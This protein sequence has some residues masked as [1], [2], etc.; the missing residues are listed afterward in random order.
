[1]SQMDATK[2]VDALRKAMKG[3]G[4]DEA[5]LIKI[6]CKADPLYV[7]S[8][9]H[10]FRQR[11]GR[12]LEKDVKSEVSGKLEKV[13]LACLRGPL[14]QDVYAVRTAVKGLGTNED[15]LNDVLCGRS[16][17]DLRVIKQIYRHEHNRSL[18]EDVADDLSGRTK[19]LFAMITAANRAEESA[20]IDPQAVDRDVHELYTSLLKPADADLL[21]VCRVF[22]S[23]SNAQLRAIEQAYTRRHDPPLAKKLSASTMGH[24]KDALLA[25]LGG[26]TDPVKRDAELLGRALG[27]VKVNDDLLIERVVRLHWNK[28]HMQ[29]VKVEFK[30]LMKKDLVQA[31]GEATS[32]DYKKAMLAVLEG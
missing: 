24:M 14:L 2:D 6:L 20:P 5:T 30:K 29:A 7:E 15:L 12:N 26:A 3:L 32:G 17:A 4:T 13:L 22:S 1:M 23:R 25:I 31:V 19:Q 9:K 8:L 28:Q 11:L 18:D 21:N 16:N 27:P 10:T